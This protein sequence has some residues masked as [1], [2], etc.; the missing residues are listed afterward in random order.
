MRNLNLLLGLKVAFTVYATSIVWTC[1]F[2]QN[3]IW[4]GTLG[5]DSSYANAVTDGAVVVGRSKDASGRVKAF[6]WQNGVME[7]LDVGNTT[8]SEAHDVSADGTVVVGKTRND[9][10]ECAFYWENGVMQCITSRVPNVSAA[11]AVSA[12]G[13]VVVGAHGIV[14]FRWDRQSGQF[15]ELSGLPFT[16]IC[17]AVDV[18]A[19]GQVITGFC[20]DALD[21]VKS[22]RLTGADM[23][24]LG[25]LGGDICWAS[26]ISGDGQVVVGMATIPGGY[27]QAFAWQDSQIRNLGTLDGPSSWALGVDY[28]G[29]RI[30]GWANDAD[31]R[32]L[33]F[34]RKG[35]TVYDLNALYADLLSDGS[36]LKVAK[37][38]S[39]NGR[40]IVGVGYNASTQREEAF[41]LDTWLYGDTNGNGCVGDDDL[42]A[43]IMAYGTEGSGT[44]RYED[45]NRDGFVDDDDLLIV[46]FRFGRGCQ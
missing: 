46:L 18:S 6:R 44:T 39:P 42:L 33:A 30:V 45:I 3:L 2:S 24:D 43:L 8:S 34:L 35:S 22:F 23:E 12:D 21:N 7:S 32:Q 10:G 11:F 26:A 16:E 29:S 27:W 9:E 28:S 17:T 37:S 13:R 14:A 20:L 5:G 19:D 38:V 1:A 25:N 31:N 36:L 4:L 40:F 41:L 15:Q